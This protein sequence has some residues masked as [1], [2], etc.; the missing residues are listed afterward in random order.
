MVAYDMGR[1]QYIRARGSDISRS[2]MAFISEEY[3]DPL[4]SVWL[5]FSIPE[6]DGSWRQMEAEG[7]VVNVSDLSTGCRFGVTFSRMDPEERAAL[8][9]F[10]AR[11]EAGGT[12]E[13]DTPPKSP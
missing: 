3:V 9:A 10:I 11:L 5:S 7:Y 12:V 13:D 6:P 8:E 2:G 1:E 4:L